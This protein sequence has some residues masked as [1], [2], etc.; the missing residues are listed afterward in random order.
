MTFKQ[1]DQQD[2]QRPDGKTCILVFGYDPKALEAIRAYAAS[3]NIPEVIDVTPALAHNTLGQLIEGNGAMSDKPVTHTAPAV[4][5]NGVSSA[6]LNQ[7][8]QNFRSLGLPRCL[9]AVV[10]ETSIRWKFHDLVA[11]LL[12]ERAMFEKM[13]QEK[14]ASKA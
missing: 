9:F 2:T 8:V 1:I 6:E 12:E 5:L 10:T 14:Q 4:V 3:M 13:R 11:D 7:F